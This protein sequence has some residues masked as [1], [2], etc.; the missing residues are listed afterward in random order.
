MKTKSFTRRDFLKFSA[1]SLCGACLAASCARGPELPPQEAY[2]QKNHQKMLEDFDAVLKPVRDLIVE[3]VGEQE[4]DAILKESRATYEALL[5]QVPYI[6]GED[7]SLS[8][9]LYMSAIAL[10]FYQVMLKHGQPAEQT[11]RIIYR[12][13]EKL[14]NFN[15]PLSWAM[16]QNSTGK[17]AQDEYRRMEKWSQNS[18]YSGDWKLKF[19]EGDGQTF[20]FGVDYTECGIVKFFKAH[21][22]AEL[23]PYMCLGDFPISKALNTGLVRTSTLAHGGPC[24]DFRFK[25]GRAVQ[26]EWTPDFLKE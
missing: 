20:D 4:T 1:A 19:V 7:N 21:N 8:E 10:A 14:F 9:T 18:P 2:L 16:S 26:M 12:S 24:C 6:G 23:G 17:A 5:P 15:D 11:G 22:A 25:A 3:L 13:M